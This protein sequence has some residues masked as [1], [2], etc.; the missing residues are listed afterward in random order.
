MSRPNFLLSGRV[1]QTTPHLAQVLQSSTAWDAPADIRQLGALEWCALFADGRVNGC[2]P[3]GWGGLVP[4]LTDE[5][6]AAGLIHDLRY[7]IGGDEA[8]KQAADEAFAKHAP[9]LYAVAV[10]KWGHDHFTF[11]DSTHQLSHGELCLIIWGSFRVRPYQD[12]S[13]LLQTDL[14]SGVI[15]EL[16]RQLGVDL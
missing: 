12:V 4:D 11:R 13:H 16:G 1:A 3:E 2:G 15:S 6:L 8:D 10:R 9:E 7:L 14:N 5:M